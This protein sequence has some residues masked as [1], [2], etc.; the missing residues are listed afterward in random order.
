MQIDKVLDQT[1]KLGECP[2]WSVPEQA[3]YWID[4]PGKALHRF[5]VE[6]NAHQSWDLP[7]S[8]GSIGLYAD[9][10]LLIAM[11]D[12]LYRFDPATAARTLLRAAEY[13][14]DS[15]RYND[16]RTD[17]RGRFWVGTIYE[18]TSQPLA[19]LYSFGP[20]RQAQV[21]HRGDLT[22]ANGLAFSPDDKVLYLADT[23]SRSVWQFDYDLDSG[24]LSNQRPFL[25]LEAGL[26]RPDGAAVDSEGCYWSALIGYVG[27]FTPAGKLDRLI[28]IPAGRVTMCAFGGAQLETLF[29]TTAD[30]QHKARDVEIEPLAGYVLAIDPGVKGLPEP[31]VSPALMATED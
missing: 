27:R 4:I 6:G 8:P 24:A 1:M 19:E 26:G 17:R 7:E 30:P 10:D 25:T 31:F 5:V 28:R 13:D 9:G 11:R 23:P 20:E 3:L 14:R 12:G 21:R 16:G 29:I 22:I 15:I 2:V 18:P